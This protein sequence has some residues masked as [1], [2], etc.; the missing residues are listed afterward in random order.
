MLY[1]QCQGNPKLPPEN[2]YFN[3]LI[4]IKKL[5]VQVHELEHATMWKDDFTLRVCLLPLVVYHD[6]HEVIQL[7]IGLLIEI[8]LALLDFYEAVAGVGNVKLYRSPQDKIDHQVVFGEEHCLD[9]VLLDVHVWVYQDGNLQFDILC[10]LGDLESVM[11][12][13]SALL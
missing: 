12:E 11:D 8:D 13:V 5:F 6:H 9:V 4:R 7:H 1:H 3:C 2:Q 10:H